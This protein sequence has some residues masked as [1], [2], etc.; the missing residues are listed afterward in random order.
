MSDEDE[1]RGYVHFSAAYHELPIEVPIA[2][3]LHVFMM[4]ADKET[5]DRQKAQGVEPMFERG[6]LVPSKLDFEAPTTRI[7]WKLIA[8]LGLLPIPGSSPPIYGVEMQLAP[9]GKTF[10]VRAPADV[11]R[12]ENTDCVI[13]R[14]VLDHVHRYG[15]K[16]LVPQSPPPPPPTRE[17]TEALDRTVMALDAGP[18]SSQVAGPP[19]QH[20]ALTADRLLCD[21]DLR[22]A[23][24]ARMNSLEPYVRAKHAE[25]LELGAVAPV[26]VIAEPSDPI[27][28]AIRAKAGCE[29]AGP[30]VVGVSAADLL[31]Q[32]PLL[33]PTHPRMP[34][35]LQLVEHGELVVLILSH[36]S[37][38]LV[39]VDHPEKNERPAPAQARP[40]ALN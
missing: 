12:E 38:M 15:D 40:S 31:R 23:L 26:M 9:R 5:C 36:M 19:P 25:A 14:D 27:G 37:T 7:R 34:F 29:A 18:A 11:T 8:T 32:T 21:K 4:W 17:G 6:V 33:W 28:A 2:D 10:A 20:P 16:L 30:C 22:D 39:F 1:P 3:D 35:D 24:V 13:G